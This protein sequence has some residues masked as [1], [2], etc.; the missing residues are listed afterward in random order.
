MSTPRS[1]F[2]T[3]AGGYLGTELVQRL[4]RSHEQFQVTAFDVR[5]VP[6]PERIANVT[7]RVGDVRDQSLR[8]ALPEAKPHVVVHLASIVNP[9]G[10][11][12]REFERS[13]DVGGTENV[14]AACVES[15]VEQ[16]I[17]TSSGASYGYHADN[18]IPLRESD[19]LRGNPEFPYADHKRLIEEQLSAYRQSHPEL[20]Q[21]VLRPG[22]VL[23]ERTDNQIT[24]LFEGRAIVGVAGFDTPFVFIWDEDVVEI[25]MKGIEEQRSGI[26]NLAGDGVVTLRDIARITGKKYLP[27]PA[28]LFR[29]VLRFM[30][31]CGLSSHGPDQIIFLQ[32]RPVLANDRLKSEFEYIPRKTSREVFDYYWEHRQRRADG[33]G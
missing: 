10:P 29:A 24:R 1:I 16:L 12:R 8:L 23:G 20:K 7:Y 30:Q 19:P 32:Y 25:V 27:I 17:V 15:N 11:D 18:P 26:Y 21:L 28:F 33:R 4:A 6:D 2:I 31:T 3:G 13:V 22:T 5:N 14:L 9:G